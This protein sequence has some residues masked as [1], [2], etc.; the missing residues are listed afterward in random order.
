LGIAN[1]DVESGEEKGHDGCWE[2]PHHSHHQL[3]FPSMGMWIF[4]ELMSTGLVLKSLLFQPVQT[5][6][7]GSCWEDVPFPLISV[8]ELVTSRGKWH[9]S[10]HEACEWLV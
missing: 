10:G 7:V 3:L 8:K 9:G 6:A 5:A 2:P 4:S 1:V